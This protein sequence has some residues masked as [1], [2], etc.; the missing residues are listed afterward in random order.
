MCDEGDE[1]LKNKIN[2]INRFFIWYLLCFF[3][4]H[5]KIEFPLYTFEV[6]TN[7][8]LMSF[9][10]FIGDPSPIQKQTE[11]P[12]DLIS[13]LFLDFLQT[14]ASITANGVLDIGLCSLHF[15]C[16]SWFSFIS[17]ECNPYSNHIWT[18]S[19]SMDNR[20]CHRG[21]CAKSQMNYQFKF[22]IYDEMSNCHVVLCYV[23]VLYYC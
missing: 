7:R 16:L 11:H 1:M 2:S 21:G 19:N 9:R 5:T 18:L 4:K 20:S 17:F 13:R 22:G 14:I 8:I 6:N 15:G 3:L 12:L 23:F 10:P